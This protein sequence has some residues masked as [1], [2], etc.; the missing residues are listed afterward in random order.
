MP[1]WNP[2][3]ASLIGQGVRDARADRRFY[4]HRWVVIG[5]LD[6]RDADAVFAGLLENCC[7]LRLAQRARDQDCLA[8]LASSGPDQWWWRLA[9][10][11]AGNLR[12]RACSIETGLAALRRLS[13][14]R[15]GGD[16][17]SGLGQLGVIVAGTAVGGSP[18]W[19]QRCRAG[20]Q[21]GRSSS[22][23]KTALAGTR[24]AIDRPMRRDVHGRSAPSALSGK[25][26]VPRIC[27]ADTKVA[28]SAI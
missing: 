13:G 22:I 5:E 21:R 11:S 9:L 3:G 20:R 18:G 8:T 23:S 2:R 19:R 10:G 16:G 12:K 28:I 17:N 15:V 1:D 7:C 25:K 4:S 6:H 27:L 14:S 26:S 24:S